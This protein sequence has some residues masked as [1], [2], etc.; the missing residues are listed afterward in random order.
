MDTIEDKCSRDRVEDEACYSSKAVD[1]SLL[2]SGLSAL[3]LISGT[4]LVGLQ[5]DIATICKLH[6]GRS[7][8]SYEQ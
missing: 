1:C 5:H 2:D 4:Y 7:K 8:G 6:D 3:L